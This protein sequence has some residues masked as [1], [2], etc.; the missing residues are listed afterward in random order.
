MF[1]K[2]YYPAQLIIIHTDMM[3][4]H[5]EVYETPDM[6]VVE[7]KTQGII[8]ASGDVSGMPG[9]PGGGDPFNP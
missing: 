1:V 2:V 4:K 6:K 5:K 7:L 8:C 3:I 9:Y